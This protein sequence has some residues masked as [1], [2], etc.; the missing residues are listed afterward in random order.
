VHDMN[1]SD[2][3]NVCKELV[4]AFQGVLSWKWDSRFETVLAEFGVDDKDR[5]REILERY[6]STVWDSSNIGEA[7]DIVRSVTGL[8]GDPRSGQLILTTDLTQDALIF[9]AWW[10]WGNGKTTSIRLAPSC[11]K[12]SNSEKA[13]LI[14]LFKGCFGI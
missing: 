9:C 2:I 11:E 5:I 10:P 8:I 7:P 14:K 6:L 13:E 4:S 1:H 3:E 12:L